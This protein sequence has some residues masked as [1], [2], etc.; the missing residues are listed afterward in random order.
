MQ[1]PQLQQK[2]AVSKSGATIQIEQFH[3]VETVQVDKINKNARTS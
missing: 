3:D 1:L 2:D